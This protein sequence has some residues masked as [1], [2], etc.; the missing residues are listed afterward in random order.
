MDAGLNEFRCGVYE[1]YKGERYFVIG[2]ARDDA[3]E[4]LLV[5]YSRLYRRDGVPL[6]ARKLSAFLGDV[7]D[8]SGKSVKRFRYIGLSDSAS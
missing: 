5:I 2:V 4:E 8:D 3:T 6:S 1:H 7:A